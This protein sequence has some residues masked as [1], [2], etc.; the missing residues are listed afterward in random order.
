MNRSISA[1]LMS[2][3]VALAFALGAA[4][5]SCPTGTTQMTTAYGSYCAQGAPTGGSASSQTK[6]E[7]LDE[8]GDD[9]LYNKMAAAYNELMKIA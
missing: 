8:H 3:S 2:L 6:P 1:G 7:L 4:A 5:Q 9:P